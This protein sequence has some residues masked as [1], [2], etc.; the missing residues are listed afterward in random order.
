[1]GEVGVALN[2]FL[3]CEMSSM[4]LC[5]HVNQGGKLTTSISQ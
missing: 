4:F 3:D 1:M 5:L 2:I